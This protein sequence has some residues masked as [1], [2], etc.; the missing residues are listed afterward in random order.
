MFLKLNLP[1]GTTIRGVTYGKPRVGNEAWSTFFDSQIPDFTRINNKLDPVTIIPGRLLG[2]MHPSRE[3]HIQPDESVVVCPGEWLYLFR[4][5]TN[6]R[7]NVSFFSPQA[8]TMMWTQNAAIRWCRLLEEETWTT[9]TVLT[10]V[11]L[12]VTQSAHREASVS[13]ASCPPEFT[14]YAWSALWQWHLYK[15][16]FVNPMIL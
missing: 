12:L 6:I 2:F 15:L 8:P 16:M 13:H 3:I 7:A 11:S 9:T 1:E 14:E 5:F 4:A 10:T